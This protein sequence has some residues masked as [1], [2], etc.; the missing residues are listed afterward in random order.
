MSR[1]RIM[2]MAGGGARGRTAVADG[3]RHPRR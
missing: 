2:G 3:R 1:M